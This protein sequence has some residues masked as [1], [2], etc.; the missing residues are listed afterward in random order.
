MQQKEKSILGIVIGVFG[1]C[2]AATII[3]SQGNNQVVRPNPYAK[4]APVIPQLPD[5]I[6]GMATAKS[7]CE[8]RAQMVIRLKN[9]VRLDEILNAERLY[10]EAKAEF[11]GCITFLQAGLESRFT[12]EHPRRIADKLARAGAKMAEYLACVD[13]IEQRV[14]ALDPLAAL[15][16]LLDNWMN[17]TARQN[18]EAI[19]GL[20]ETLETCRMTPWK[21]L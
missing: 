18:A 13:R 1:I 4:P 17:A 10:G 3:S 11:D 6:G 15:I 20:K 5:L 14:G 16:A 12:N 7:L 8:S 9:K 2:A 21:N 19:K